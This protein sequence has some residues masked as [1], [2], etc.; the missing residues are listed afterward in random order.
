MD[1]E[2]AVAR[3]PIP[4]EKYLIT[5]V[6]NSPGPPAVVRIRRLLKGA[7]RGYGLRCLA[8]YQL[9]PDEVKREIPH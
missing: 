5:L 9:P 6:C 7:K 2:P 8:C 4:P 1:A 3:E